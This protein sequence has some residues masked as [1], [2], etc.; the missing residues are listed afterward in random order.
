MKTHVSSHVRLAALS[1][2]LSSPPPSSAD[3]SFF[4]PLPSPEPGD[5]LS[6]H[7]E[8]GQTAAQYDRQ[9]RPGGMTQMPRPGTFDR[10]LI[11]PLGKSFHSS[12]LG[13]L[14][15]PLLKK[16]AEAFFHPLPV[17]FYTGTKNSDYV[18]LKGVEKR[19]ND[20]GHSQYFCPS[21]FSLIDSKTAGSHRTYCRL[22]ITLEDITPGEDWN[23]VYGQ[24]RP[25]E[26]TG[27]FSFARHSPLFDAGVRA[28]DLEEG[29]MSQDLLAKLL[30]CSIKTMVHE[31]CHMFRIGH[32]I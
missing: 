11:I 19:L 5:W 1:S 30:R 14:F 24:A 32:C 25:A 13:C 29:S 4:L 8:E 26:R 22:G 9:T 23:F 17:D 18:S 3:L 28:A 7:K 6:E 21:L 2:P 27:V 15:L 10:V 16:Y 20:H 12:F 31:T